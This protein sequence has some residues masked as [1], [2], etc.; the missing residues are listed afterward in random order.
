MTWISYHISE[1]AYKCDSSLA[2]ELKPQNHQYFF[3]GHVLKEV[4]SLLN[5]F[6]SEEAI[7]D[8]LTWLGADQC[9]SRV[10]KHKENEA[11]RRWLLW[12]VPSLGLT[13]IVVDLTCQSNAPNT[14]LLEEL[15]SQSLRHY[16][17]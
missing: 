2:Y 14:S 10:D 11:N 4:N 8:L 3:L 9:D 5:T 16:P 13:C 17:C 6:Y 12:V 7:G 1:L 15:H